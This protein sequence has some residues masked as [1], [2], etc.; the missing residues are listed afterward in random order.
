MTIKRLLLLS[1]PRRSGKSFVADALKENHGFS[2]IS[3]FIAEFAALQDGDVLLAAQT[4]PVSEA[5]RATS[6]SDRAQANLYVGGGN[7]VHSDA[8][9]RHAAD[10]QRLFLE[11][12]EHCAVLRPKLDVR[13][14]AIMEAIKYVRNEI[15]NQKLGPSS[16][17][18]I[19][20][21]ASNL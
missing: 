3:A 15:G 14:E 4:V 18:P 8:K 2:G 13:R 12:P 7:N 11:E 5:V 10:M 1:G 21:V 19:R 16:R 17:R 6:N 20:A 9:G